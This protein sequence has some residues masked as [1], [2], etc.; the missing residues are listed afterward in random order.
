MGDWQ[1]H[2]DHSTV[3]RA[4]YDDLLHELGHAK[5]TI[6]DQERRI[7]DQEADIVYWRD[8]YEQRQWGARP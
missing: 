8:R 4:E 7:R 2:L 3:S 5:Q 6:R 1:R